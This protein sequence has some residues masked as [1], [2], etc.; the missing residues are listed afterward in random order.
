MFVTF[1]KPVDDLK[2][3]AEVRHGELIELSPTL[4]KA[5]RRGKKHKND[6][7]LF[8]YLHKRHNTTSTNGFLSEF[9][10]QTVTDGI[11]DLTSHNSV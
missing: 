3:S 11:Q 5:Q 8:Y 2:A 9:V 4:D 7:R 1:K 10:D 6:K